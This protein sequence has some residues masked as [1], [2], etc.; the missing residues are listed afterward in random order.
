MA[1]ALAANKGRS[2]NGFVN[3]ILRRIAS[4][5]LVSG[6]A[7]RVRWIPSERNSAD[8]PSRGSV[9]FFAKAPH[10]VAVGSPCNSK[11]D[12]IDISDQYVSGTKDLTGLSGSVNESFGFI[13]F[14]VKTLS[15]PECRADSLT[16]GSSWQSEGIMKRNCQ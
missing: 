12:T 8:G 7:L 11:C 2:K 10:F 15:S 16:S 1:L 6:C 13:I 3:S 5:L 14:G 4:L 9:G